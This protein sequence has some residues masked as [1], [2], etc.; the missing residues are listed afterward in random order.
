[1]ECNRDEALRAREIAEKK[2]VSQDFH[3]AQKFA[4]KAQQLFP[5]LENIG[6]LFAVIDVHI[7]AQS[8]IN[9]SETDWYGILQ[10]EPSADDLLIKKQYRRLALLLHPDKN[11][12]AGA[13]AAFKLIGEASQML[14]DKQQR[15]LHDMKR[16]PAVRKSQKANATQHS[17]NQHAH[18]HEQAF[19]DKTFSRG[20]SHLP[21]TFWTAC[22]SCQ[23][24]FQYS[25][26]YENQNLICPQC[27]VPFFAKDMYSPQGNE[28]YKAFGW[29]QYHHHPQ[30]GGFSHNSSQPFAPANNF[31]G[32]SHPNPSY[33][34][35]AAC[36]FTKTT[37]TPTAATTPSMPSMGPTKT[38]AENVQQ[39]YQER[40]HGNQEADTVQKKKRKMKDGMHTETEAQ[41]EAPRVEKEQQMK[42]KSKRKRVKKHLS[43]SED[44][45]DEDNSLEDDLLDDQGAGGTVE[46]RTYPRRSSRPRRNVT[47]KVDMSD[48]EDTQGIP[49]TEDGDDEMA[50]HKG[51]NQALNGKAKAAQNG[52]SSEYSK[53]KEKLAD[54][55]K[56]KIRMNLNLQDEKLKASLP[57]LDLQAGK[58]YSVKRT[59][60]KL[61][62]TCETKVSGIDVP[63]Q[64]QEESEDE[65]NGTSE[66][67]SFLVPDSDFYDF[68]K[69]REE[70]D[71]AAGQIWAAYDDNDGMPRYYFRVKEVKSLNPFKVAICWLELRNLS[72]EEEELKDSGFYLTCGNCFKNSSSQVIDSVN[73]F[74]HIVKW[75]KGPKGAIKIYPREKD[76]WALYRDW[77]P[78]LG[79]MKDDTPL[80]YDMVEVLSDFNEQTGL[81]VA[82][83]DKLTGFKT[84]FKR[85]EDCFKIPATEHS[86][87]SHQV[88]AHMLQGDEVPGIPK[89]C[90]ELD[91]ASV[92]TDLL[93]SVSDEKKSR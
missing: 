62:K 23:T 72:E 42:D 74:S 38:N 30:Q 56:G 91:P 83:L 53:L 14:S 64:K 79:F 16:M 73:L 80:K 49:E 57:D 81:K 68:D 88:P 75:E 48:E 3:G 33:A 58:G 21:P 15:R 61:E 86:R 13:E 77:E 78:G 27:H 66:P 50:R 55:A 18:V 82:R 29:S 46:S 51:P 22:P 69:D 92:P 12:F 65:M 44:E 70:K 93:S 34:A 54:L 41:E 43:D 84:L 59:S 24:R 60:D 2:L 5:S 4:H 76:V 19:A 26:T 89:G 52:V 90:C 63:A 20:S 67:E 40:Q 45:E 7:A 47:Y 32:G 8:K 6:Q 11:K 31:T 37:S 87:F 85:T 17:Q 1:M 10:V 71:V 35:Q 9:G 39:S 28:G 25:R 36:G